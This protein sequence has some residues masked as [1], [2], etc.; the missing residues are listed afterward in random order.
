MIPFCQ[1]VQILFA[2]S[3][4]SLSDVARADSTCPPPWK[5]VPPKID[6]SLSDVRKG[7]LPASESKSR[8]MEHISS[9]EGYILT[10]TDGSK[11]REGVGSAFVSGCDIRSFSLPKH[12]S[13]FTSELVA[14]SKALS[15]IEVG[16]DASHLILSDSLSSLLALRAF[17]P[18][19]PLIQDILS[20]LVSL[21]RAGKCVQFCWLPSHV[22]IRGNETADAAARR[23]ASSP[24][25]RC[26]RLPARDFYPEVSSLILA[27]WQ[28]EWES[29]GNNKLR[30]L[31]PTLKSWSS[32]LRRNRREEVTLCRLRI[33]HTY[34]THGYLLCGE[35]RPMCPI[36]LSPITVAHV[37]LTCPQFRESRARHLGHIPPENTLRHLLGDD[38]AWIQTGSL[39]SYVSDINF[40]VI[41]SPR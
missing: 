27:Q 21:D 24:C 28:L 7:D 31:K 36:C 23:A 14:I 26:L 19:N 6:L 15:F 9:Y 37:L 11:T 8:A 35:E 10:F 22:G 18:S 39:F 5:N 4:V 29:D 16:N 17:N 20:R 38:S 34:A 3:D 25:T 30:E 41:Y 12:S 40:L 32:S 2:K 13:V 33:G 1:R